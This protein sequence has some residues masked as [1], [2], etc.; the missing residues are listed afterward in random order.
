MSFALRS[1]FRI[2]GTAAILLAAPV[3]RAEYLSIHLKVYGLDCEVCARGV[4]ASVGR[5]PGIE[6]VNVS[7]KTGLLDIVL[8]RGNS[9]KM[10]DLRNRIKENGFRSME[11]TVTAV[12]RFHGS[13]FEVTGTGESYDLGKKALNSAET[14]ELT[15]L[16][17]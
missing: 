2:G 4:S 3:A 14:M 16:V 12:G 7:L 10:S 15:F 17:H 1:F 6:S 11:A 8:A 13:R 5:L 9:F